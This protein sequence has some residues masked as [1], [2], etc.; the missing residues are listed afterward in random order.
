MIRNAADFFRTLAF[1]CILAL[2]V[3]SS[4][5]AE[6]TD[7]WFYKSLL[8]GERAS[9]MGGAFAAIA[10]D[11]SGVWYNPAGLAMGQESYLSGSVN[12]YQTSSVTFD[13]LFPG[14]SYQYQSQGLIPSFFGF[15]QQLGAKSKFGF[16]LMVRDSLSQEQDDELSGLEVNDTSLT[17]ITRQLV[18]AR[19]SYVVGPSFSLE[20]S[21]RLLVGLSGFVVYQSERFLDQQ[22]ALYIDPNDDSRRLYQLNQMYLS[23]EAWG[24]MPK[25]GVLF[26]PFSRLSIGMTA[27]KTFSLA[28]KG[29]AKVLGTAVDETGIPTPT[30][31]FGTDYNTTTY[32]KVLS[33]VL[34]PWEFSFGAAWFPSEAWTLSSQVDYQ[35][36]D[37]E[38]SQY[39]AQP[40]VNLSLGV[41]WAEIPQFPLR[42]GVFTNTSNTSKLAEGAT[43]QKEHVDQLGVS[44]GL[45]WMSPGSSI[46]VSG[47]YQWGLGEGQI[48]S[49]QTA[50]QDV[51]MESLTF[52][53]SGSYQL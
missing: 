33:R 34:A 17:S 30:G 6:A 49:G 45:S 44:A 13:D 25:L 27:A 52:F 40:N 51:R 5:P 22:R 7:T 38:F 14:E 31:D 41:E 20:L 8:V 16:I 42:L 37:S 35:T 3:V 19:S 1:F 39:A 2:N 36:A 4:Q 10:D 24:A 11:P 50:V 43:D 29:R 23:R 26:L 32:D 53:L 12:A 15:T 47:S 9:G 46:S 48:L 18:R 28:G 21:P